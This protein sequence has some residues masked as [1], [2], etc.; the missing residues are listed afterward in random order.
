[1]T[2]SISFTIVICNLSKSSFYNIEIHIFVCPQ[3][4]FVINT[5]T[6]IIITNVVII[7]LIMCI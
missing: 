6:S 2:K 3:N 4:Q 1:M 5:Y 7:S